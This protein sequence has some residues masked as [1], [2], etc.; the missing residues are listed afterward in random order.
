MSEDEV[1]EMEQ[2]EELPTGASKP[3]TEKEKKI[4][5]RIKEKPNN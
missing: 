1:T 5:G 3:L 2:E 4:I